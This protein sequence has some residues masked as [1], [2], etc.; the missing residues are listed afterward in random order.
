MGQDQNFRRSIVYDVPIVS[1]NPMATM[2]LK[3]EMSDVCCEG[4]FSHFSIFDFRAP[5]FCGPSV[6]Y[7]R[8]TALCILLRP[9]WAMWQPSGSISVHL[10]RATDEILCAGWRD[11]TEAARLDRMGLEFAPHTE[12]F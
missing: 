9:H 11:E 3:L 8:A 4:Q 10:R 2:A 1:N 6:I 5:S 7:H 12:S